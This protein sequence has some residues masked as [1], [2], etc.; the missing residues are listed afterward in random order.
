MSP[1]T[2]DPESISQTLP[3]SGG[4]VKALLHRY[5]RLIRV[6]N[7]RASDPATQGMPGAETGLLVRRV[8]RLGRG[9]GAPLIAELILDTAILRE[10]RRIEAQVAR[11]LDTPRNGA[12]FNPLSRRQF[13]PSKM[14]TE[15]QEAYRAIMQRAIECGAFHE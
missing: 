11:E 4:R 3:D 12:P 2:P 5:E 15:D 6:I 9:K 14:S 10:L 1:E 7:A 8:R 13:D